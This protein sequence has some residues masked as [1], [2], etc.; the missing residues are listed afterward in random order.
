VPLFA[1]SAQ[2]AIV[3]DISSEAKIAESILF[4]YMEHPPIFNYF[5]IIYT[6]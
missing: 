2:P 1:S 5:Y 3:S 6:I 4:V